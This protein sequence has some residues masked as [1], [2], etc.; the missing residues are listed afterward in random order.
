M[1]RGRRFIPLAVSA[2]LAA[3]L[4]VAIP[5]A[6]AATAAAAAA[7]P[8]APGAPSYFD[9]A[10]K[11]CLG[12]AAGQGSKVWYT[13]ADGVLSDV[14]EPTIDNT[15]V[16]TLQYVVTDGATFTDLQARDMTY[17]VAA[18]PT[19]MACTV[20]STDAKHG[21]RL[22]TTYITDPASDTVLMNTRLQALPGS[23][24]NLAAAA[25]VRPARR[26]RQRQRRRRERQR[27][28]QLRRGGH[29]RQP[30]VPVV[31]STN[32]VTNAANRDYAVPTYMALAGTSAQAASVGYAGTASDGLNELDT[33]RTLTAY[34]SAPDGH[35]V[36]T[37]N[38][39]P[40]RGREVTLALGFGRT[41]AQSVSVAE[42]SLRHPFG[43]T[44]ASYLRGWVS[45]DAG[46]RPP[47]AR[48]ARLAG[49]Y[50]LSANVLKASEDKTFPGA[51]VA[52]LASPWGQSVPAGVTRRRRAVVLRLV[53]RGVRP[54]PVRG[55]HRADGR[56]GRRRGQ[57]RDAVPVRPPAASGRGDAAQLAAE[58]QGR[59]G[60][61]RHPAGRGRLPDPDGL[62]GRARR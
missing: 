31:F 58:R 42:G 47:P 35:V 9:L 33:A 45:Y 15:D 11:D 49:R 46:L 37:E 13:V 17:T 52:S 34:S 10:R 28:R 29:L 36:A 24:A 7:A 22:V 16:S 53:P 61:R 56:R 21:F 39:T 38:V 60:H 30:P 51:I 27:G 2:V 43:Q 57:G 62:P 18:D 4:A 26:P 44:A 55:L 59:P 54:G 41:Q 14:Y 1:V 20:T 40:G 23:G 6:S 48:E 12:T 25:P 3:A 50:Y 19:G 8:G 5:A 32:T